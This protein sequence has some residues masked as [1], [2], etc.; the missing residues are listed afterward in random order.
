M[1]CR[2]RPSAETVGDV[3]HEVDV[4]IV[5]TVLDNCT[6]VAVVFITIIKSLPTDTHPDN[7]IEP[8]SPVHA[9]G[10]AGYKCLITNMP[11]THV[12]ATDKIDT[13]LKFD[14]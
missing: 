5:E 2:T 4:R 8:F 10:D 12:L 14:E 11:H 7:G 1:D 3:H 9:K 13:A 6:V